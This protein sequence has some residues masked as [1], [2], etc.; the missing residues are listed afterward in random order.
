[1]RLI[2]PQASGCRRR[3]RFKLGDARLI[4]GG[5]IQEPFLGEGVGLFGETTA[6]FCL[7]FQTFQVH[8]SPTKRAFQIL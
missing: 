4:F 3:F 2:G 8:H 6:A 7:L 1:L 5:K